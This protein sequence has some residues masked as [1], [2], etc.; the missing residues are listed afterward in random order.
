MLPAGCDFDKNPSSLVPISRHEM[1]LA[2]FV[3]QK[4]YV[5]IS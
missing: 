3:I 4:M 2:H 5:L 1:S